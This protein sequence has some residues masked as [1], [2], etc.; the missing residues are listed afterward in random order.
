MSKKSSFRGPF[1]KEHG[2]RAQALLKYASHHLH[3]I[4]WSL[5]SQSSQKKSLLLKCKI[6]GLLVKTLTADYKY[7]VLHRN[8]LTIPIQMQLSQKQKTFSEFLVAFL[9]SRLHLECFEIKD[10]SHRFCVFKITDSVNEVS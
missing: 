7:P 9:K 5:P 6:L 3:V 10:N 1:D 2:R 8:N 4:H